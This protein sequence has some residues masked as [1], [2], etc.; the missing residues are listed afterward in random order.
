MKSKKS[1]FIFNKF[2]LILCAVAVTVLF[3]GV[4]NNLQNSPVEA[5]S[6]VMKVLQLIEKKHVNAPEREKLING[7]I[8]GMMDQLDPHSTFI[9][10]EDYQETNE[11]MDGE[12][13]GI[14]VQFSII[15]DYITVISPIIDG[16]AYKAGIQSGDQIVKIDGES[17]YKIKTPDVLKKLKGPK[18]TEVTVTISRKG[19]DLFDRILIRDKIAL[20]SVSAHFMI[21]Q[22][23]GYIKLNKFSRKTVEE[24]NEA[25][26]ELKNSGMENLLL[27]LRNNPGG[28]LDQAIDLLDMFISSNDTLLFTKGKMRSANTV[29]KATYSRFDENLPIITIINRGSAS[30]SEII[31]GTLQ[32]LDRGLVIGETSFGKGSVQQ[33]YDLDN[34]TAVRVTVAKYHT[35]SGRS[36]QRDYNKGEGDYYDNLIISNRELSDSLKKE[37]PQF[38]TK[39]G[40]TVYGGGGIHPDIYFKDTLSLSDPAVDIIYNPKQYLF[41]YS[42]LL[43]R[44]Y[45]NLEYEILVSK[46]HKEISFE[47][48]ISWIKTD[49]DFKAKDINIEELNQDWENIKHRIIAE[50]VNKFWGRDYYYKSLIINDKTAQEA[51]KYFDEAKT[52]LN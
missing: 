45:A 19:N 46:A 3:L 33:H 18:G 40:R 50:I 12:F 27:D 16:P 6:R 22:N 24:F 5:A 15:D 44:D 7:A 39:G 8:E 36:I 49:T 47:N 35:P 20:N 43:K 31:S 34:E 41:N 48:F 32:D 9:N 21:D 17:A 14:G 42:E 25:F 26:Y 11:S 28:L 10:K 30:A 23:I 37:L 29:F 1:S 2:F 51:L 38:K 4:Q 52:L 13:E